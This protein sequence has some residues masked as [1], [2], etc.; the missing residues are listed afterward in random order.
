M[1]RR[2]AVLGST[3]FSGCHFIDRC[4]ASGDAVIGFSRSGEPH[5]AFAPYRRHCGADLRLLQLDINRDH[6]AILGELTTFRP[7]YVVNFAAQGMVAPSWEHPDQWYM[8][9]LV[10]PVR[11]H[12]GLRRIGSLK[13]F[14]QVSTPEVY[15][16][17]SGPIPPDTSYA[18]SSPYAVSKAAADMALAADHAHH[19]FPVVWTRAANVYGP[20]QQLY[21]IIPRAVLAARMGE[22]LT[23]NGGGVARRAFI[24]I[25][26]VAEA[27]YRALSLGEDGAIHHLSTAPLISIRELVDRIAVR[28]GIDPGEVY[29][30]GP[31]RP[32][33]DPIYEL[34][35]S[36]T[37]QTL[38]WSPSVSLDQGI[39]SVIAW[40]DE[41]FDALRQM[42]L[43]YQHRP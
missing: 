32:T 34:D 29:Q 43:N 39:D 23:L 16:A 9:N 1:T 5:P 6:D 24:H 27:T 11:L 26:D 8:T 36:A 22:P 38:D 33:E 30:I 14:I 40:V 12:Q 18:P 15:G 31:P 37:H 19:D 21:R 7:E 2:V 35:C 17:R 28:L 42:P 13:R 25:T 10:S 41:H 3:S 20:G 4:L